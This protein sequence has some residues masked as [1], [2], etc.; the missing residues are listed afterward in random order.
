M[1]L[2]RWAIIAAISAAVIMAL[3]YGFLP[4]PVPVDTARAERGTMQVLIEEE[5]RTRV[6]ER[7]SITAPV[8]GFMRRP[9][10]KA[11]DSVRKGETVA[12]IE[13]GRSTPLDPRTRAEAGA[14]EAVALASLRTAEENA[15][16]ATAQAEYAAKSFART[17]RL[18]EQGYVARDVME[19]AEADANMKAALRLSSEA[20]VRAARSEVDRARSRLAF[21]TGKKAVGGQYI[22]VTS[23]ADGRVLRIIRESEL[24]VQGG[25]QIMEIGNV[26]DIEVRVEALT[27]DATAIRPGTA[28]VFSR[29]GG[30]TPLSGKVRVV[31]PSAFT[32]VS[33]LGVEEQRV[34]IISDVDAPADTLARLGDGYRVEAGF[35]IWEDSNVLSVPAGA[36]FRKGE[37][38]AVFV[39]EDRTAR[40]RD[41]TAGHRNGLFVEIMSGLADG[42]TVIIHPDESVRDGVKVSPR[43]S[44]KKNSLQ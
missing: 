26:S 35:V 38:W 27:A 20:T 43:Q 39:V 34:L 4:K 19:Q 11:G 21:Y 32:K 42:A 33:S 9:G 23:P 37:G 15:R 7:F 1:D 29:W 14:S 17:K 44:A 28:V 8:A 30:D 12:E 10:L 5:G 13:P 16:S 40:L 3:I 25:D 18:F 22:R 31:E 2:R 41:I 36:V 24:P 6:K